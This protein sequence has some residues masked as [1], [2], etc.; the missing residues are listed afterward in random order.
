[1]YIV[2]WYIAIMVIMWLSQHLSQT[3][4]NL[5]TYASIYQSTS[6]LIPS[7]VSFAEVV[8]ETWYSTYQFYPYCFI[9]TLLGNDSGNIPNTRTTLPELSHIFSILRW[10]HNDIGRKCQEKHGRIYP[11]SL[12][13]LNMNLG[14]TMSVKHSADNIYEAYWS[15]TGAS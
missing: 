3:R 7:S 14:L 11:F 10:S 9:H 1:M 6:Q 5:Y 8:M 2:I 15:I 4:K 13:K 12:H